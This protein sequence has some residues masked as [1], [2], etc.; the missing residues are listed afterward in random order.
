[1]SD[2][3]TRIQMAELNLELAELWL[4]EINR[5]EAHQKASRKVDQRIPSALNHLYRQRSYC[6]SWI[7]G[8][9]LRQAFSTQ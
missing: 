9:E 4:D 3:E 5:F 6:L 2:F 7:R 1:M 8:A